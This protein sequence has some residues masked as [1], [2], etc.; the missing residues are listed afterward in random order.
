MLEERNGG[1]KR[2][3]RPQRKGEK[4]QGADALAHPGPRA[5]PRLLTCTASLCPSDQPLPRRG[6][7]LENPSEAHEKG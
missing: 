2:G 3:T 7:R 1:K 6:A 5:A 4:H